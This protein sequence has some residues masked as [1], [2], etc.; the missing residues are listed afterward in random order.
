MKILTLL[1]IILL[2]GC[3]TQT[4]SEEPPQTVREEPLDPANPPSKI[5]VTV[6]LVDYPVK[7]VSV[8]LTKVVFAWRGVASN[9]I[10]IFGDQRDSLCVGQVLED[11]A[12]WDLYKKDGSDY[13]YQLDYEPFGFPYLLYFPKAQMAPEDP[14]R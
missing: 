9:P 7:N 2:A 3:Q 11:C 1:S 12:I 10:Y 14:K 8:E 6:K 4:V 5:L 13:I